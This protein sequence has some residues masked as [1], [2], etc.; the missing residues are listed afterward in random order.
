MRNKDP[1]FIIKALMTLYI[2]V[3]TPDFAKSQDLVSVQKVS[4]IVEH[5]E[6]LFV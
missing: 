5:R 2:D 3:G 6:Q 1:N 4:S